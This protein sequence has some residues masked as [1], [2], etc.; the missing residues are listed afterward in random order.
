MQEL[1]ADGQRPRLVLWRHGQT[2]WNV[3]EKAQGHADIPLDATGRRQARRAA[4]LL[5]TLKPQF[6]WSSDLE[7]AR[8]TA[9]ALARLTG[10]ETVHDKRLRE[11]DVGIR[12]GTTFGEFRQQHPEIHRKFFTEENYR[13][14]GAELPSEVNDRMKTVMREAALALRGGGTGVLVGHGAALRSGLMAF[15]DAPVHMREMF[16]GMA[17][18]AWTVLEEHADRGWQIVDYNAR[19]LPDTSS[20]LADDL[21]AEHDS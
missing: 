7:R 10:L 13:V 8:H 4:N 19:T 17:N 12:Q 20:M 1:R 2:E 18:C 21:P 9:D 16:A 14:P 5:A 11:Y 15:F 3:L 6:I